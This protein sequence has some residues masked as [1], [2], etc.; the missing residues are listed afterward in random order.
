MNAADEV[1]YNGFPIR[2]VKLDSAPDGNVYLIPIDVAQRIAAGTETPDDLKKIG[3]IKNIDL[4]ETITRALNSVLNAPPDELFERL[5][6]NLK[7]RRTPIDPKITL[8]PRRRSM[9]S[10]NPRKTPNRRGKTNPPR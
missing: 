10:L 9:R 6:R 3:C 2:I 1:T 5:T 8:Q 4:H 7:C